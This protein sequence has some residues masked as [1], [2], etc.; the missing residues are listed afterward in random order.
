MVR[1][2][3][4][5]ALVTRN[6]ILDA[7]A[8]LFAQKGVSGTTLQHIATEA[9]VTRGAIYWH[10]V[11][12][13]AVFYAMMER[14]KLPFESAMKFLDKQDGDDLLGDIREYALM[15]FRFTTE[16]EAARR[17]FE[18]ATLKIEYT[19]EM[20]VVHERR[21]QSR[22][23]WLRLVEGKVKAGIRLGQIRADAKPKTVALALWVTVEG[24]V[25]SSV[26]GLD[27][28]LM[29]TGGEIVDMLLEPLR[30]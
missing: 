19:G 9:G 27:F 6:S 15:V 20:A 17:A 18:I 11:D 21:A 25:R 14:A 13:A 30:A 8:T 5:D 4:E 23:D 29:K 2:T 10:F 24:L 22:A 1:K 16:D 28:N 7:A 26:M 3:K 12:K